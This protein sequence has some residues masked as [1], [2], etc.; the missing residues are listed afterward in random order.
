MYVI[1]LKVFETFT[2]LNYKILYRLIKLIQKDKT[3]DS[4]LPDFL[5]TLLTSSFDTTAAFDSKSLI[6]SSSFLFRTF[7]PAEMG[8]S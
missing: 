6:V 8:S 2:S 5:P 4:I 1:I 3:H 7:G